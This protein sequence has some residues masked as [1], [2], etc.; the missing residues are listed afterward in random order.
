MT[1]AERKKQLKE[2]LT[3]GYISENTSIFND[4][5]GGEPLD[6]QTVYVIKR[7]IEIWL[8]SWIEPEIEEL[9]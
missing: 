6:R 4:P 8:H 7:N 3:I 9:L 5:I 1:K 2:K